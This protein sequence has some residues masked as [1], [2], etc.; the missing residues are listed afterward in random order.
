[1]LFDEE[2]N[3][4]SEFNVKEFRNKK[5]S[6]YISSVDDYFKTKT[7]LEKSKTKLFT[8]SPEVSKRKT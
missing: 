6:L 5:T 3:E 2:P 7:Y 8:Y 4:V 1:M